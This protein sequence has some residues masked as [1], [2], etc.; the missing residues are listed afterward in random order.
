MSN[1]TY[2]QCV[3]SDRTTHD[4]IDASIAWLVKRISREFR[5]AHLVSREASFVGEQEA[6]KGETYR[7]RQY[8]G[9]REAYLVRKQELIADGV[10]P[11]AGPR[12][13][14]D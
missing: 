4:H 12:N 8:L 2:S 13:L 1:M 5:K 9:V 7:G 6:V 10:W 14:R 3:P 11:I